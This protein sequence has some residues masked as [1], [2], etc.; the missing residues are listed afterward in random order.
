MS[1]ACTLILVGVASLISE[2]KLVIKCC[3]FPFR[4]MQSKSKT[5]QKI[6]Q[7]E[8]NVKYMGTKHSSHASIII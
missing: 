7:V 1:N 4:S 3:Q 2:I 5:A 8:T 6:M